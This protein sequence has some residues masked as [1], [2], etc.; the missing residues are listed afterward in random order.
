[1]ND[2]QIYD[3]KLFDKDIVNQNLDIIYSTYRNKLLV[4]YLSTNDQIKY[5]K[6]K[7]GKIIY[8]VKTFNKKLPLFLVSYNGKLKGK[9][10]ICFKFKNWNNKLPSGEII[11]VIGLMNEN[12][13]IN[14]LQY[15]YEINRK[16][17]SNDIIFNELEYHI[18][19]PFIDKYIFSID[20]IGCNDIDDA[21]SFE[22]NNDYIQVCIY[23]AQPICW[24]SKEDIIN[25]QKKAFSTLYN[26]PFCCN[27][28][29]WGD[30]ITQLASL[31]E[32]QEKPV[33]VIEIIIKDNELDMKHYP[34]KII[35]KLNT[36]YND[37]LKYN[38]INDFFE[39][40][41]QY[42]G[43]NNMNTHELVSFW[44]VLTN[45]LL[46][47][48]NI[49]NELNIPY[50][51]IN[52]TINDIN[53]NIDYDVK[54]V[55]EKYMLESASYSSTKNYHYLL[56][57]YNYIHFTSPIRR[58]IDTIIHYCITYNINFNDIGDLSLINELDNKTKKYHNEINLC[59]NINKLFKNNNNLELDGWIYN[60][61]S[62]LW[63][64]YF[65]ELGFHKIKIWDYD[66]LLNKLK[67]D[68]FKIG[69]KY[70]FIICKKNDFLPKDKINIIIK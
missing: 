24:L 25:R 41:K 39:F 67:F 12:N 10:I 2:I 59:N 8:Q 37:C 60:K 21:I 45:N 30:K 66:Y 15:I 47:N 6:N 70:K 64:I 50:R 57:K 33:Y 9:I 19:R 35:N 55:F 14:T 49:I 23:I 40:T 69:N 11:N 7:S 13:L 62:T 18:N 44:M 36:N 54:Q 5:G 3:K 4:G 32:N 22:K 28:N 42:S 16:N 63:I 34:A 1:M 56:D 61:T 17:F 29:L 31:Y 58:I 48:L 38:E 53:Y 26:E 65:K 43:N 20:P 51:I 46:G 52:D 27:N 68:D